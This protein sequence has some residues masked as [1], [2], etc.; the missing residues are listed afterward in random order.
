M[1]IKVA[2]LFAGVGGFRLGLEGWNN[3]SALSNYKEEFKNTSQIETEYNIDTYTDEELF[4]LDLREKYNCKIH[5]IA[6]YF[7]HTTNN[8]LN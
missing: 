6:W 5:F 8:F 7:N 3:K 1:K 4:V 2:E